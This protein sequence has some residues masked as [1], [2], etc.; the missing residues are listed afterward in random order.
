[1]TTAAGDRHRPGNPSPKAAAEPRAPRR[2]RGRPTV[3]VP[4][5]VLILLLSHGVPWW[6]LVLAPDWPAGVTT[7]GTA[8]AVVALLGF[9]PAM[10]TGHGRAHSDRW[11]VVGDSWLGIV[12]QLFA[13][14]V[15]AEIAGLALLLVVFD[16]P[17]RQRFSAAAVLAVVTAVCW[18]GDRQ[19]PTSPASGEP[20]SPWTGWVRGWTA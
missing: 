5:V 13:W 15:I 6:R 4:V 8:V 12:W 3:F 14:T 9:P 10:I 18:S 20:T 17:A 1:M 19:V 11:A 2:R 16:A 7:A